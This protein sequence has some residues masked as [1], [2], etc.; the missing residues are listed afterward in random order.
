MTE[1]FTREQLLNF[2]P[3][4]RYFAGIDSDGCIFPTMDIKQKQCFHPAI[5]DHWN[6]HSIEKYVREAAEFVNL[7]SRFRGRNRFLCL[8]DN[9]DIIRDRPEVVASGVKV[10]GL[11]SLKKWISTTTKLGNPELKKAADDSGDPELRQ[12]LEW[13]LDVNRRIEQTVRN[14]PPFR[15]ALKS[16]ELI[17]THADAVCVSQTPTEALVREW[18]EN[19]I[20]RYVHMIAGQELGSK[21]EHI[22]LATKGKYEAGKVIMIGDAPGDGSAAAENNACFYPITPGNEEASWQRFH[23]EAFA[24]FLAGSYTGEYEQSVLREFDAAL[25]EKPYWRR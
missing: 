9:M 20:R 22:A 14:I 16:L 21:T 1:T 10:P 23:D 17:S 6:L 8:A 4:H 3:E 15:W 24:R 2:K 7:Y 12:V 25:P 13:S 5:L 19:N 11:S 18:D